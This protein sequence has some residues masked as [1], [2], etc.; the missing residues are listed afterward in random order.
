MLFGREVVRTNVPVASWHSTDTWD[1]GSIPDNDDR[2]LVPGRDGQTSEV[3]IAAGARAVSATTMVGKL[4]N[5]KGTLEVFGELRVAGSNVDGETQAGRLFVG[6]ED[7]KNATVIQYPDSDVYLS[8]DL[9]LADLTNSIGKYS[10]LGGR[11]HARNAILMGGKAGSKAVFEIRGG[12]SEVVTKHL[13]MGPGDTRFLFTVEDSGL[14]ALTVGQKAELRGTLKFRLPEDAPTKS[15]FKLLNLNN[16]A[17]LSGGFRRVMIDTPPGKHYEL[18]Y[19]GGNNNDVLLERRSSPLVRFEEWQQEQLSGFPS[20]GARRARSDA[21]GDKLTNL[22]EYKLGTHPLVDEGVI[23]ESGVNDSG[24]RLI[25]F[26]E[27]TDRTDVR[28]IVQTSSD[29]RV[30]NSENITIKTI[31]RFGNTRTLRAVSDSVDPNLKFRLLFDLVPDAGVQPNILFVTVDDLNDFVEPLGGHPQAITSNFNA[32]AARGTL[33]ANAH[34]AATICN[35]SRVALLTGIHP[36]RSGVYGN[37]TL[38]R[39]SP[40]LANVKTIPEQFAA[41]GYE[42]VGAGKIF[43]RSEPAIW[44]DYFPSLTNHRPDDP[45]P[46]SPLSGVSGLPENFDWGPLQIPDGEMGDHQVTTWMV[47]RIKADTGQSPSFMAL[48]IYRPHLPFHVPQK[49]FDSWNTSNI[50]LPLVLNNDLDDVPASAF[51]PSMA[52]GEHAVITGA[53]KWRNAVH[54]YLAAVRFADKQLG[55]LL[56]AVDDSAIARNTIIVVCSD[57]GWH[58]GE[59]E[60]WRKRSLWEESTRVPLVIIA[61]GITSPGTRCEEVVSLM[62]LYPTLVELAGIP[63]PSGLDGTSLLPQLLDVT[64]V[65]TQPALTTIGQFNHSVRSHEYRLN[66]YVDGSRELFDL[67]TDPSEWFNLADDPVYLDVI[68]D[69]EVH[70]PQNPAAAVN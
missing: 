24:R 60:G 30:W 22:G 38:L 65:R 34:A 37:A 1:S 36:S 44:S 25:E 8:R 51:T 21:D 49:Y 43:H 5:S 13:V 9:R 26:V 59:K 10:M 31:A 35:A 48:G 53:G 55:R 39:S 47:N 58:L 57:H 63:D 6:G 64:A 67:T 56:A 45:Q 54:G 14:S 15:R 40:V 32:L 50:Q 33:F 4:D 7:N 68:D 20:V 3:W 18:S 42:S 62:D 16:D 70:L 12:E 27:R 17:I 69:L 41:N 61:P 66:E 29:G 19:S 2:A 46:I 28:T 52:A 11:L 23:F